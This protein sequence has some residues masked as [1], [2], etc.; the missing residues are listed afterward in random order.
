MGV[1]PSSG[2]I[3]ISQIRQEL[4]NGAGSLRT[5]SADA[6]KSTPDSMSEF[7]GY[8]LG[9]ATVNFDQNVG[10]L[11]DGCCMSMDS[12]GEFHGQGPEFGTINGNYGAYTTNSE[13]GSNAGT[14][15]TFGGYS[16]A[17]VHGR[18]TVTIYSVTNGYGVSP[19]TAMYNFINVNGSRVANANSNAGFVQVSYSFTAAPGG[20]YNIDFGV[21]YGSV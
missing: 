8:A 5:L 20:T 1:I 10:Q 4:V 19:N 11:Y 2:Q 18:T 15:L 7:L 17:T 6:G 14:F 12:Y 13:L 21:D 9:T 16:G 3:S